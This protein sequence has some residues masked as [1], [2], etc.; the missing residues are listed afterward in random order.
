M[1]AQ[2]RMD[3]CPYILLIL[4]FEYPRL[5]FIGLLTVGQVFSS[6]LLLSLMK[7]LSSARNS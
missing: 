3:H 1:G 7:A 4:V 2:I 5:L 6:E